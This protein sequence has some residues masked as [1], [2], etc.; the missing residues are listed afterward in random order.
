MSFVQKQVLEL[1]KSLQSEFGMAILLITHDLNIVK[2]YAD[3][4]EGN[5]QRQHQQ[6]IRPGAK[7]S[8][9]AFLRCWPFP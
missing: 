5:L 3:I 2:Q 9:W 1:L 4:D 8:L 7:H 6:F